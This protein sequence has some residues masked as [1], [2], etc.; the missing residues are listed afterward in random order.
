MIVP[1]RGRKKPYCMNYLWPNLVEDDWN[2]SY[3]FW[4]LMIPQ[5]LLEPPLFGS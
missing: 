2:I 3:I 5:S 4:K 1:K